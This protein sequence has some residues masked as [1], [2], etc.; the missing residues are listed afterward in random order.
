[1]ILLIYTKIIFLF[2]LKTQFKVNL[3]DLIDLKK[4]LEL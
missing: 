1:M 3:G 4:L 2:I